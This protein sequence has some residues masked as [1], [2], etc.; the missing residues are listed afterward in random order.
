MAT[1]S[2]SKPGQTTDHVVEL[3]DSV[4]DI[5]DRLHERILK[6]IA[7]YQDGTMPDAQKAVLRALMDNEL[8]L[9][10]HAQALY[11]DATTHVIQGLDQPQRRLMALT[12]VAAE[13]IRQI[14]VIGETT[15]LVGEILSLVGGIAT[16][17]LS[18]VETALENIRLHHATLQALKP[19]PPVKI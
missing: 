7:S 4:A 5:A 9:R 6:E 16:G 1:P 12:A 3:A 10:Q 8:L 17:R 19:T 18:E 15:G 13:Q 11:S 14:G 2:D